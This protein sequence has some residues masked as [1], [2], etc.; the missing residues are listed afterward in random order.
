MVSTDGFPLRCSIVCQLLR[1]LL[2]IVMQTPCFLIV[3]LIVLTPCSALQAC[4]FS[5]KDDRPHMR[6]GGRTGIQA[7]AILRIRFFADSLRLWQVV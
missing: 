7:I 1:T 6:P 4:V 2:R 5:E 3:V